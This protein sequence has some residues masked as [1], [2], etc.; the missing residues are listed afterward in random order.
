YTKLP[1]GTRPSNNNIA[2]SVAM[3]YDSNLIVHLFNE[4]H[5]LG[6]NANIYH[7]VADTEGKA[8]RF[9]RIEMIFGKNKITS[10]KNSLWFDFYPASSDF[11]GVDE[12][13]IAEQIQTK[14]N[15]QAAKNKKE[16]KVDPSKSLF[17]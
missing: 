17:S 16:S 6:P 7:M 5:E 14:E 10:F 13:I 2:E 9:P 1:A 4:L 3:E 8:Q 15:E 12:A 11:N